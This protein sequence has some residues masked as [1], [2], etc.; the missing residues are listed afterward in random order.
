MNT[1]SP[2]EEAILRT[3][4]YGE[5]FHFAL[6]LDEV[7]TYLISNK[8]YSKKEV[9]SSIEELVKKNI[10]LQEDQYVA[11]S[12]HKKG[13]SKERKKKGSV[14]QEKMR[15][16]TAVA[17]LFSKIPTVMG[18]YI[19]GGVSVLNASKNDDIDFMI[20]TKSGYL[21]TTRLIIV[22]LSKVL[23]KYRVRE[24]GGHKHISLNN[25]WC[26]N[27]WL[28]ESAFEIEEQTQNIYT[29]HEVVQAK[30]L[31]ENQYIAQ[32]FLDKNAWVH[33]YLPNIV[34]PVS[35]K[36][37]EHF[38]EAGVL[39][40]ICFYIQKMYMRSHQTTE[41][42]NLHKAFFHPRDTANIVSK[43]YEEILSLV[44]IVP[45][46]SFT[47]A[48]QPS[49]IYEAGATKKMMEFIHTQKK[50]GKKV[51]LATGVFD[52]LHT[53]HKNFL[54][55]AKKQ[56]DILVVAIESDKR[57]RMLKGKGRPIE[58]ERVRLKKVS[59]LPFVDVAFILPKD[60]S[61]LTRYME[62]LYQIRP[63]IY[64]CS[65]HTLHKESKSVLVQ[66][67]GGTLKVVHDHIKGISTTDLLKKKAHLS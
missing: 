34:I 52:L 39:E 50:M 59:S 45:Y 56:G 21:W 64:A 16:A 13:F 24:N 36:R 62:L 43:K 65:E 49:S 47:M 44:G 48:I 57:A 30:P 32:A 3:L 26:L 7:F 40:K 31:Y 23:G 27:L 8:S 12:F 10:I 28:D 15:V 38:K 46:P 14:S 22:L 18:V 67:Y 20:M 11:L 25:S 42:V 19:T 5:V 9:L 55:K 6:S 1:Y 4:S 33:M 2:I 63:D 58:T 61:S 51:V 35:K 54:E 29:A 17:K 53:E 37:S 60:F 41:R 66:K